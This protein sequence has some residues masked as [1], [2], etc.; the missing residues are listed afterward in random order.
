MTKKIFQNLN[1]KISKF[2]SPNSKIILGL[3]GGS[4]SVAL[5]HLFLN[6]ENNYNIIACHVNH[7]IDIDQSR[8]HEEFVKNYAKKLMLD[9]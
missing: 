4:D 7:G 5:L 9:C 3:S 8:F 2:L 1:S 6:S